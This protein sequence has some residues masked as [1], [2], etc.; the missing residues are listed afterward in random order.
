MLQPG[1]GDAGGMYGVQATGA[2]TGTLFVEEI[3]YSLQLCDLYLLLTCV[4]FCVSVGF[5][6]VG[7]VLVILDVHEIILSWRM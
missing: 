1:Y 3:Y 6:Q 7:S 5:P 4:W 2:R